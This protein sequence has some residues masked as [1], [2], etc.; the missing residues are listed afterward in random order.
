MVTA[1]DLVKKIST[2]TGF[3]QKDISTVMD[4]FDE[5]LVEELRKG[6]K[7]KVVQGVSFES[8][9]KPASVARN[10]KTGEEVAVPE[11]MTCKVKVTPTFKNKL[12]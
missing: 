8:Y 2:K 9:V 12:N 11:K 1:K 10:P 3:S 5:V 7:I 6:E 4:A